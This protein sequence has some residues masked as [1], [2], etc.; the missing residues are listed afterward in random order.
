M[1]SYYLID[2]GVHDE[3]IANYYLGVFRVVFIRQILSRQWLVLS[4]LVALCV[5]HPQ[6]I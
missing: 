3:Y 5:S 1:C 2:S 4:S 6:S